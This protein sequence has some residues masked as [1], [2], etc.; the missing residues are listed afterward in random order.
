MITC[1]TWNQSEERQKRNSHGSLQL[2]AALNQEKTPLHE[3][4]YSPW[5]REHTLCMQILQ[6]YLA[7]KRLPVLSHLCWYRDTRGAIT[8]SAGRTLGDRVNAEDPGIR[9]LWGANE[10]S[11]SL[12]RPQAKALDGW[13]SEFHAKSEIS[14]VTL[15]TIT[16]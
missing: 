7:T 15:E 1:N 13:M 8:P 11:V 3:D 6:I 12:G 14:F 2:E 4:R 5:G 16:S 9:Q 10:E